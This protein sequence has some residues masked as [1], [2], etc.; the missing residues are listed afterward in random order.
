[1]DALQCAVV[2]AKLER[3]DWEIG[4]RIAL[5][6]RYDELLAGLRLPVRP[7]RVKGDRTSVFGQYTVRVADRQRVQDALSA[8]RIPTAVHYPASLHQQ[9]AYAAAYRGQTFPNAEKLAQEV[10]SLPMSADLER[11]AQD[12]VVGA[13]GRAL[14]AGMAA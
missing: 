1:M 11:S 4:Q 13:M 7:I 9:P 3:F 6:R 14:R 2:L 10:L 12:H 8:Q 5:G